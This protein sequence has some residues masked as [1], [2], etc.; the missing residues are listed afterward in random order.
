MRVFARILVFVTL[1]WG[2]AAS[3][4][5][6]DPV[7][8]S[9]T[10]E[11]G[12]LATLRG[13]LDEGL[14]PEFV[15]AQYGTGLMIAAWYGRIDVMAL[16]VERGAN[17]RRA[18]RNGE[19]PLQLAA[20]NGH[21]AA[22]DWLLEH[23]AALNR[24]GLYWGALHYA[25]FNGHD[26]LARHLIERGA[27]VNAPSPN[28]STPLMLAAREGRE[29][30]VK[31][32]L[33]SGA[34]PRAKSDWGD[35]ALTMAMRYDRFQI[36]KMIS[37]PEEF[38]IAVKAP[39]ETFGVATRS[40]SA[41]SQIEDLMNRIHEAE[42]NGQP[43]EDLHRQLKAAVNALRAKPVAVQNGVRPTMPQPYAP[44]TLVITGN[45]R[46]PGAERAQVVVA[47]KPAATTAKATPKAAP[48]SISITP[49]GQR[50]TQA[51]IA[52]TMRQIRLAEAQGRPAEALRRQLAD[53]VESLPAQ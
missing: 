43:S 49:S 31:V 4:A 1:F 10:V 27:D 16:F 50:A 33:E 28:G 19:Q 20:W 12:D 53:L 14:D 48:A 18:N 45:R 9:W 17:P 37:T 30:L 3:A 35:T 15:G 21:R 44:R 47:G 34:D 32:L 51:Q 6:P 46:Q 29:K 11:R 22:V 2:A 52:E 7:T 36:A 41:P 24:E 40:A 23:G 8:F 26:D 39:K 38:A 13:W 5:L 25:V 42:A